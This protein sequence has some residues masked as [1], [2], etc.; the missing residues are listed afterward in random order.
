MFF[1]LKGG[2]GIGRT[3]DPARTRIAIAMDASCAAALTVLSSLPYLPHLGFYSDDWGLIA[4]FSSSRGQSFAV[5]LGDN[6][7]AR[8]IQGLYLT[9]LYR[10]FGLH[11]LGYHLANAAVL[12]ISAA[13]LYLLLVRLGVG[14]IQSFA[15]MLMFI[16]LPQ[17]STVRVWYAAFQVPLSMAL[18]LVSMHC[19]LSMAR[20]GNIGWPLGAIG[21][22]IL[23]V[24]A[25]EIFAPLIL[26]FALALVFLR[27]RRSNSTSIW[28]P[29]AGGAFVIALG[30]AAFEYKRVHGGRAVPD[31]EDYAHGLH[32]LFRLDYDCRV[33]SGLNL[34]GIT[35]TH[36]WAPVAGWWSGLRAFFDGTGQSEVV[37]LALVIA[38]IAVWRLGSHDELPEQ[39]GGR[40]LLLGIIGFILGNA[41]FVFVG[42]GSC[43]F[44]GIDN[45][46]QVAA[47]IGV[48]MIFV[49][50]ISISTNVILP[51][52][53]TIAF[54]GIIAVAG[55]AAFTRLCAIEGYW[56][57]ASV[58]QRAVLDTARADLRSIPPNSTVIL[59]RVCPYFGPAII[60]ETNWDVGG[61]LTL[62]LGRPLKGD[63][64]SPRMSI[65][66][67]GLATSMYNDP[68]FYPYGRALYIYDPS[69]HVAESLTTAED[70]RRYFANRLRM[71]CRGTVGRGAEV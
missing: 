64:V 10:A 7:P 56:A 20:S 3:A 4:S 70:A 30:M 59:D 63:A 68:S 61:A 19:Q 11:P 47:A 29:L 33:E 22:A 65:T 31:L 1:T 24:G 25:Y 16:M 12:A 2:M 34:V 40:L 43:T 9:F 35:Q 36:F 53:H 66:A 57:K 55:A 67:L 46:L 8:P 51:R 21:A 41:T 13:L 48:A 37:A 5:L 17:L 27:W 50:V 38:A 54:S 71:A 52:H 69:T 18:M 39:S 58:L 45:R 28:Q 14:R 44:T 60:F 23:S 6:F 62:A 26:G 15:T 32:K 49:A 42:A